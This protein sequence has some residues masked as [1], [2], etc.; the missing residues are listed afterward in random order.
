MSMANI[1]PTQRHGPETQRE[2]YT[3]GPKL[4]CRSCSL[5]KSLTDFATK[6]TLVAEFLPPGIGEKSSRWHFP[7][8]YLPEVF[9][10]GWISPGNSRL[11]ILDIF[12]CVEG[13]RFRRFSIG[14]VCVLHPTFP[15]ALSAFL[16]SL[17]KLPGRPP[18][19]M[20]A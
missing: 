9:C 11:P 14:F 1:N 2:R 18:H 4:T 17:I 5:S 13:G 19:N 3:L 12:L 20:L 15:I 7:T 6:T 16:F 10:I 8:Y